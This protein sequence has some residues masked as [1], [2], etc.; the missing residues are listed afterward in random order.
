MGEGRGQRD[1]EDKGDRKEDIGRLGGK[2]EHVRGKKE[3]SAEGI[4]EWG[5]REEIG[6][7]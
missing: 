1:E 5:R 6:A 3:R 7:A 4:G 2:V